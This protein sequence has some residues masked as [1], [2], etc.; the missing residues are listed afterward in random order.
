MKK[1]IIIISLAVFMPLLAAAQYGR[2]SDAIIAHLGSGWGGFP[3]R[4]S[5]ARTDYWMGAIGADFKLPMSDNWSLL[6]GLDYQMR[7]MKTGYSGGAFSGT[8]SSVIFRG[9]YLRI[10]VR[11]EYD[12]NW[13]YLA[14][15]SYLGKGFGNMPERE[16]LGILGLNLELGTRFEI[17]RYDRLRIGLPNSFGAVFDNKMRMDYTELNFVLRVGYEHSF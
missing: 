5:A 11:M 12:Y 7:H 6:V 15:G 16:D 10:P 2:Q 4:I 3:Q 1:A 14:T 17:N 13:F 8:H 9:H